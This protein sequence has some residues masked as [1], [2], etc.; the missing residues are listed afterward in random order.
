MRLSPACFRAPLSYLHEAGW[1]ETDLG[2]GDLGR[3]GVSGLV[4]GRGRVLLEVGDA[5]G[6]A[7]AFIGGTAV[8]PQ[9][10]SPYLS[11]CVC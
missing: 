11:E 8:T 2:W 10:F 7:S 1:G 6:D 4:L 9:G 3:D 5:R